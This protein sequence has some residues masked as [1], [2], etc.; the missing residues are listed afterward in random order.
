MVVRRC[1]AIGADRQAVHGVLHLL[2]LRGAVC[3]VVRRA[4]MLLNRLVIV[5]VLP[6]MSIVRLWLLLQRVAVHRR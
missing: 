4:R 6:L 2:L 3:P 1:A 5:V